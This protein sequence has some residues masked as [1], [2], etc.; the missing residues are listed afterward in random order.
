[1]TTCPEFIPDAARNPEQISVCW[2]AEAASAVLLGNI[3]RGSNK[4][5][6]Q[7][8][9]GQEILDIPD[10]NDMTLPYGCAV[11]FKKPTDR[12]HIRASYP[13][14]TSLRKF[15][16]ALAAPRALTGTHPSPTRLS[17]LLSPPQVSC[18]LCPS[19]RMWVTLGE[20]LASPL[21]ETLL[22]DKCC[23]QWC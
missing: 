11:I 13:P 7:S 23:T 20:A 6:E 16:V 21:K 5:V 4:H 9:R 10:V 1:M 2:K 8:L 12:A 3:Q 17:F 19:Q 18:F 14:R 22:D 15:T